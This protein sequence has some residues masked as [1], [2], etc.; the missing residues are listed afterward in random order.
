MS[1]IVEDVST[2]MELQPSA[3]KGSLKFGEA[4]LTSSLQP[5]SVQS[6][7]TVLPSIS[8]MSPQVYEVVQSSP[9]VASAA[10]MPVPVSYAQ[11]QT[12][13][14]PPV[15]VP[16]TA[17]SD[18]PQVG[19]TMQEVQA[20]LRQERSSICNMMQE[21]IAQQIKQ[22][23]DNRNAEVNRLIATVNS[24]FVAYEER[25]SRLE[26][27]HAARANSVQILKREMDTQRE[28]VDQ[29]LVQLSTDNR[30][31]LDK[32]AIHKEEVL[33]SQRALQRKLEVSVLD[34]CS[35]Q[36]RQS[37]QGFASEIQAGLGG[38]TDRIEL[39]EGKLQDVCRSVMEFDIAGLKQ[40]VNFEKQSRAGL[41]ESLNAYRTAYMQTF[42]DFRSELDSIQEKQRRNLLEPSEVRNRLS[43]V[44]LIL[45]EVRTSGTT[46]SAS[47]SWQL[48]KDVQDL[49]RQ[50]S[51]LSQSLD[52]Y[53][54]AQLQSSTEFL[55]RCDLISEKLILMESSSNRS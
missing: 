10:A 33:L 16:S 28:K 13:V 47:S 9:M 46:K 8:T 22:G 52:S 42:K 39:T 51:D 29:I 25:L 6:L 54:N 30:S 1:T 35:S 26:A 41:S 38:L 43:A 48:Q 24:S 11:C 2:R 17:V 5:L 7:Q 53:R 19:L 49:T 14:H 32:V 21:T 20:M 40:S 15:T 45:A 31:L 27:D 50:V 44:E 4:A 3:S 18:L 23:M 55:G 36:V 37:L 34:L 12:I